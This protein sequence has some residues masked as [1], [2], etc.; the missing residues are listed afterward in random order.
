[1][2]VGVNG[3]VRALAASSNVMYVGGD[4]TLAGA[5]ARN[6]LC[7][8]DLA[9]RTLTGWGPAANGPVYALEVGIRN[10]APAVLIGGSFSAISGASRAN[11]AAAGIT[12]TGSIDVWNPSPDGTVRH[13]QEHTVDY[14]GGDFTLI[15]GQPRNHLAAIDPSTAT[16]TSWDPNVDGPVETLCEGELLGIGERLVAKHQHRVL[17]HRCTDFS[18]LPGVIGMPQ[19]YRARLGGE[20]RMQLAEAQAH[21]QASRQGDIEQR[22][23]LCEGLKGSPQRAGAITAQRVD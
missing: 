5:G 14:I 17:I 8:I 1:M 15:G 12:G 11:L 10:S 7:A 18:E 3:S 21:D 2:N 22:S 4:F 13:I 20:Q 23:T 6:R 9:T 19:V 16:A